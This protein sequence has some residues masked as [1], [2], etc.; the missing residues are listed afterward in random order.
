MSIQREEILACACDIY[1]E[2]GLAGLSMRSMAE[3]IG[4]TAPALYRHYENKERVLTDL[5]GEAYRVLLGYLSRGLE[6]TSP[7]ER[8]RRAGEG[9]L[10]F[11]L[12]Q[13]RMYQVLYAAPDVIGLEELPEETAAQACA[14]GQF[15]NDRVRE[16]MEA[17]VLE[18]DDPEDVSA[19]LWAHAHGLV[20][21]WLRGMV[22]LDAEGF[23]ELYRVSSRRVLAGLATD[24]HRMRLRGSSEETA[25]PSE[26]YGGVEGETV[27][28]A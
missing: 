13:P 17:G 20:S 27:E 3:R 9:Y 22:D 6:G 5:V 26:T 12:E 25:R 7:W 1:V 21:I 10:D 4:V 2:E 24:A 14:I 18:Q 19:T 8:F 28:R 15:W 16:C 11:A 23:R